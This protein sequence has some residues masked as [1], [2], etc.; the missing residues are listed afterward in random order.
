MARRC[1]VC[2]LK[3]RAADWD[4]G[5]RKCAVCEGLQDHIHEAHAGDTKGPDH[6]DLEDR[7]ARYT[8]RAEKRKPLFGEG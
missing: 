1:R 6:Q 3:M 4:A 8:E 2:R 5:L 7:I